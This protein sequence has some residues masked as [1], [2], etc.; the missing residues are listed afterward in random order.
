MASSY[1]K[2]SNKLG[3]LQWELLVSFLHSRYLQGS[4]GGDLLNG[5]YHM[6]RRDSLG[7]LELLRSTFMSG[8][9]HVVLMIEILFPVIPAAC[10]DIKVD[11]PVGSLELAEG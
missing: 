2:R 5:I 1:S 4:E 6:L 8:A 9:P 11:D 3:S 10:A 7:A